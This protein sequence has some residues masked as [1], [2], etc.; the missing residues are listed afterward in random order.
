VGPADP[1]SEALLAAGVLGGLG[2]AIGL[3]VLVSGAA[4]SVVTGHG[5]GPS[6]LEAGRQIVD[7][8]QLTSIWPTLPSPAVGGVALG[9]TAS[10]SCA[11][12]WLWLR[13]TA[14]RPRHDGFA[15]AVAFA[16]LLP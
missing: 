9:L 8:G 7:D 14:S 5:T 2:A 16:D 4:V 1:W 10:L 11:F 6:P 12:A 13:W 15:G 3:V